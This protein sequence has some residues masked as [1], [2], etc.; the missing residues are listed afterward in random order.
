MFEI[1][2][3]LLHRTQFVPRPVGD[4][5]GYFGLNTLPARERTSQL[6]P[7]GDGKT[8]L[9]INYCSLL[10]RCHPIYRTIPEVQNL[11]QGSVIVLPARRD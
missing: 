7:K 4:G 11:S 3:R 6:I 5:P 10:G 1:G 2:S 8:S 9:N